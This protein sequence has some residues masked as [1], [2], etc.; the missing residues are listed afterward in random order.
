MK[1]FVQNIAKINSKIFKLK[2]F[3]LNQEILV[4]EILRDIVNKHAVLE[5]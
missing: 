5:V 1:T 3:F 2:F 4:N